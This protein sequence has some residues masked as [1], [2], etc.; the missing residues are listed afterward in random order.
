MAAFDLLDDWSDCVGSA[1]QR[2]ALNT[3]FR[4]A[5]IQSGN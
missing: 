5:G 2:K 1:D 3:A 4:N